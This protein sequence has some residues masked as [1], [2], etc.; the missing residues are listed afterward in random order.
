MQLQ[1][2]NSGKVN[3][4]GPS[5]IPNKSPLNRLNSE[6]SRAELNQGESNEAAHPFKNNAEFRQ[7]TLLIKPSRRIR[8]GSG[9]VAERIIITE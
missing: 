3:Y 2:V 5:I 9:S 1:A 6:H 4:K 8:E 7:S